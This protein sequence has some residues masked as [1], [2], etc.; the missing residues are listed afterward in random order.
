MGFGS[1]KPAVAVSTEFKVY[2]TVTESWKDALGDE[3]GKQKLGAIE[4]IKLYAQNLVGAKYTEGVTHAG[5]TYN[6]LLC[7]PEPLGAAD[8]G[9]DSES[10]TTTATTETTVVDR[11]FLGLIRYPLKLYGIAKV[12]VSFSVAGVTDTTTGDV[13][14]RIYADLIRRATDGTETALVSKDTGLVTEAAG[15]ASLAETARSVNLYLDLGTDMIQIKKAEAIILRVRVAG[16]FT[17]GR[18]FT[19]TLKY[20]RGTDETALEIGVCG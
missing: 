9:S 8:E 10:G 11:S 14:W 19:G 1:A 6:H 17:V 18:T 7:Y 20:G 4:Y 3:F 15:V 2:D 12:R 13:Q 16:T 5:T